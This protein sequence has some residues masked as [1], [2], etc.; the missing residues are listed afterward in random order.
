MNCGHVHYQ[1]DL[2]IHYNYNYVLFTIKFICISVCDN[3]VCNISID[4]DECQLD[5]GGC[6]HSCINLPGIYKCEC[7]DGYS[8]SVDAHTC[9]GTTITIICIQIYRIDKAIDNTT[10]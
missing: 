6:S 1:S 3:D 5:N 7:K 2:N 4:I 9:Y 10:L 8:L